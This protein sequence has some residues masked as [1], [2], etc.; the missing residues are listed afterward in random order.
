VQTEDRRF[1]LILP[2]ELRAALR[3]RAHAEANSEAAT[4]RRLLAHALA[5]ER[6]LSPQDERK[7]EDAA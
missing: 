5:D 1:T 4:A 7:P 2:P 6:A 3:R